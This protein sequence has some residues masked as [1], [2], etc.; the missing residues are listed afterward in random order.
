MALDTVPV[1]DVTR[2]LH[3]L[4]QEYTQRLG[5]VATV[6][7][8]YGQ[9]LGVRLRPVR[10]G[11]AEVG[12]TDFGDRLRISVAGSGLELRSRDAGSV[13]LVCDAVIAGRSH[14]VAAPGRILV[15]LDVAGGRTV[16]LV[17][18]AGRLGRVP[19]PGWTRWGT[20]TDHLPYGPG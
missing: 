17:S 12:W 14:E 1:D 16:R 20:R 6:D 7:H 10:A 15:V 4:A 9:G 18:P 13:R 3:E 2:V 19:L 5:P 8:V 11:A